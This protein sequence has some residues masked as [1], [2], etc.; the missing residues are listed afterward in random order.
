MLAP[1][2]RARVD[3]MHG[4]GD[5]GREETPAAAAACDSVGRLVAEGR[6]S[7]RGLDPLLWE[8][9]LVWRSRMIEHECLT[10]ARLGVLFQSP[11]GAE[12]EH[13][14]DEPPRRRPRRRAA[15]TFRPT[16]SRVK[17]GR[18]ETA[19]GGEHGL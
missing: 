5:K 3:L 15:E 4:A 10:R 14:P 19:A 16:V 1:A 17:R 6:A 8:L 13:E 18:A 9:L 7:G 11:Q 12:H 2:V